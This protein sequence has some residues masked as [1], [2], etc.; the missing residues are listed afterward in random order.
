MK[1]KVLYLGSFIG[2]ILILFIVAFLANYIPLGKYSFNAF[3]AYYEYPAFFG[4]L[5]NNIRNG[6]SILF[7]LHA[8]MGTNFL[9]IIN[10]YC[11]SP[12]NL[13]ALFFKKENIYLFYTILVYLKIGLSGLFMYVYLNHLGTKYK[14][15]IW[16]LVFSF[17][18]ALS[19]YAMAFLMHVMWMDI[20]F[21][22]PL[23]ILGLENLILKDKNIFY[24]IILTSI[25]LINYYLGFMVCLFLVIYFL[26]YT[27]VNNCFNKNNIFKFLKYSIFS[28]MLAAVV[29]VPTIF[30]L[31]NGRLA[32]LN[33]KN[34]FSLD[35]FTLF[36]QVYNMT[37]GSFIIQ[38]NYNFG[39]TTIFVTLFVLVLVIMFFFNKKINKREKLVTLGVLLF[40]VLSFSFTLIDYTWNMFQQPIWWSHRYQFVF[41]FFLI[42]IGYNS[43]CNFEVNRVKPLFKS[44]IVVVFMF[45]VLGSLAYKL[46][47]LG[48]HDTYILLALIS[49]VLFFGYLFFLKI[50]YVFMILIILELGLNTYHTLK[51]NKGYPYL[52]MVNKYNERVNTLRNINDKF[53]RLLTLDGYE[54]EGLMYSFNSLELFSSSYNIKGANFIDKV[55]ISKISLNHQ[56]VLNYNPS[57]LSFLGVKYLI[58]DSNYYECHDSVCVNN[59]AL[60]I[61]FMVSKELIDLKLDKDYKKNINNIYSYLVGDEIE[62]FNKVNE[63]N[64]SF[65]NVSWSKEKGFYDIKENPELTI[66]YKAL[67]REIVIFNNINVINDKV[68]FYVNNQEYKSK[69]NLIVLEKD[70]NLKIVYNYDSYL[71]YSLDD[72][73]FSLLDEELYLKNIK[74]IK[75]K[76]SFEYLNTDKILKGSIDSS[77]GY[78]M[79]TIPYDKGLKIIVDGKKVDYVKAMETFVGFKLEKGKHTIEVQYIPSGLKLGLFISLG[80]FLGML[81]DYLR[82]RKRDE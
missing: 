63:D 65:K 82:K 27:L 40:F 37:I 20:Y 42:K 68:K 48:L 43:W 6:K 38:D 17:I 60:P 73:L 69:D 62:L 66:E 5:L 36:S 23:V 76:S 58:G 50:K 24:V 21:L 12:L 39:S 13:L 75:E 29:L 81:L 30:S 61:G 4:E 25:I 54:N 52:E 57:I 31:L 3:D 15:S 22:L 53:G 77:G 7:T 70:D 11:G 72:Y 51:I 2:P 10:L 64:V 56:K 33:I 67:K 35:I 44:L 16:N 26:Y 46:K 45:L 14:D 28:G 9:S 1:K 41:V 78:F 80:A 18:Y 74:L 79:F 19:G 55:N 49:I 32:S 47:G 8:G 34:L 59:E 71:N